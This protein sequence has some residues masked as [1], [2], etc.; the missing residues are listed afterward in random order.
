MSI[1]ALPDWKLKL[2]IVLFLVGQ[3]FSVV[4]ASEHGSGTHEHDGIICLATLNDVQD[5][6]IHSAAPGATFPATSCSKLARDSGQTLLK[7]LRAIRPP[8]TG[9]PFI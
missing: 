4:H 2:G 9:P 8:P 1:A 5:G 7:R 6:L 3:L